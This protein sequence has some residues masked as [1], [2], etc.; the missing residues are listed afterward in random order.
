MLRLFSAL[1]NLDQFFILYS[2]N[3]DLFYFSKIKAKIN[4]HSV[5]NNLNNIIKTRLSAFKI[6]KKTWAF[7]FKKGL[8]KTGPK[9]EKLF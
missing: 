5:L 6:E 9:I 8:K 1:F 2:Q 7:K 4:E 3:L